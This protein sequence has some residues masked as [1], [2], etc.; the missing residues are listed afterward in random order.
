VSKKNPT[1]A[2][3]SVKEDNVEEFVE[4]DNTNP[5][6]HAF[7]SWIYN[8][9]TPEE[10]Q[11]YLQKTLITEFAYLFSV[12]DEIINVQ[13]VEN[14]QE[15]VTKAIENATLPESA[16]LREGISREEIEKS[17][18]EQCKS[19]P[20][21]YAPLFAFELPPDAENSLYA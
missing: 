12:N 5:T 3:D 19:I 11:A 17:F 15:D 21:T 7:N 20:I 9:L 16:T 6:E 4:K 13:V 1:V 10:K 8:S 14:L 2:S 18:R